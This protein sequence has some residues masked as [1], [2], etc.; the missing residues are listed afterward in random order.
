MDGRAGAGGMR[1][2]RQRRGWRHRLGA[3]GACAARCASR[4]L[5]HR[6]QRLGIERH[7]GAAQ[8]RQGRSHPRGRRRLPLHRAGDG[9]QSLRSE[10]RPATAGADLRGERGPGHGLGRRHRRARDLRGHNAHG[11][12]HAL[13]PGGRNTG[14]AQ[15]RC[16]PVEPHGRWPLRVR[17]GRARRRDVRRDRAHAT[18][19][20]A[21]Q[22][23]RRQRHGQRGR[24][25]GGGPVRRRPVV[26]A[27]A[28]SRRA[29]RGLCAQVVPVQLAGRRQR[30]LLPAG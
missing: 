12:R 22:A 2:R 13:G 16:G 8:Q 1:G 18:G 15:Q 14:A 25:L 10:H 29:Q 30:H 24:H 28:D 7:A 6:R 23:H 4:E 11:G 19:R 3:C 26:A 17:A 5:P 27:A 21:V 9:R 20:A